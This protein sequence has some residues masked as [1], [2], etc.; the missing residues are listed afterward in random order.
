MRLPVACGFPLA[1]VPQLSLPIRIIAYQSLTGLG[2]P[3]SGAP[4][5]D[6]AR[7][8]TVK[9]AAPARR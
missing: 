1:I 4:F 7:L 3:S 8:F 6:P 5:N 9:S 2:A